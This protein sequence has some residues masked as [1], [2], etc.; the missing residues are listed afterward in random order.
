MVGMRGDN[1]TGETQ[2]RYNR[3][4]SAPPPSNP[5]RI[6][7]SK[8]VATARRRW[9][10]LLALPIAAGAIGFAITA[11][12]R[13]TYT[14]QIMLQRQIKAAPLTAG[15][16]DRVQSVAVQAV[17]AQLEIIRSMSVAGD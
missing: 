9:P 3:S 14:A 2:G 12:H 15:G 8:Y 5:H 7:I 10:I 16:N 4:A 1:G 6:D 11:Q 17:P 13:P